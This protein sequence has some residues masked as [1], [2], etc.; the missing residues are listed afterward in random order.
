MFP[1]TLWTIKTK[2][3]RGRTRGFRGHGG[4]PVPKIYLNF[5]DWHI[6]VDDTT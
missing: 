2:G 3:C 5:V 1:A 6:V 4:T